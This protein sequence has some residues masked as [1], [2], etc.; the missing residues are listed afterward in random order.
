MATLYFTGLKCHNKYV[1]KF[2]EIFRYISRETA[3]CFLLRGA[4][5]IRNELKSSTGR[6]EI[7]VWKL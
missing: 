3:N 6:E 4:V 2:V 5:R 7:T 1:S